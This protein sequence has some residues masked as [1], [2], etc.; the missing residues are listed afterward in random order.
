MTNGDRGGFL[1][2]EILR[3]V[4]REYSWPSF[5][6]STRSVVSV[7]AKALVPLAGRYELRP[8]FSLTVT[9]EGARLFADD[10]REKVE[11][12]PESE[13]RFFDIVEGHTIVFIKDAAGQVTHML[14]DGQIKA[15][16]R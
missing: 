11:L 1:G 4:A 7:D 2:G 3:A 6:P 5:K 9:D 16:R 14:I 10:G 12:Y 8:D 13:R 15:P